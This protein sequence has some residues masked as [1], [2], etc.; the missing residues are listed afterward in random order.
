MLTPHVDSAMIS[1]GMF[2]SLMKADASISWFSD[3]QPLP[4][5]ERDDGQRK[6][7]YGLQRH[8]ERLLRELR[9]QHCT[10]Y[11]ALICRARLSKLG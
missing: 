1:P 2:H 5:D 7:D 3:C 11:A 9:R 4:Y 8:F 6:G 10:H